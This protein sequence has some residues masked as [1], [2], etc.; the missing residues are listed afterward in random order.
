MA[1]FN[2]GTEALVANSAAS[3]SIEERMS[4][5]KKVYGRGA[6]CAPVFLGEQIIEQGRA[7]ASHMQFT[8]GTG[9]ESNPDRT[10]NTPLKSWMMDK[11]IE[12]GWGGSCP[13]TRS[14][15]AGWARNR[16]CARTMESRPSFSM[17]QPQARGNSQIERRA[18]CAPRPYH[19]N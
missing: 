14:R 17:R 19:V 13:I 4:F 9:R 1:F 6:Q 7:Q 16:S 8:C 18:H 5:L 3:A 11:L 12:P 15:G 2:S 10:H